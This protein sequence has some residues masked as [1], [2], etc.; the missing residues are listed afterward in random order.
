[1]PVHLPSERGRQWEAKVAGR[2][3]CTLF[4]PCQLASQKKCGKRRGSDMCSSPG[5]DTHE[6][7]LE[8][9][10][11]LLR[12]YFIGSGALC[13]GCVVRFLYGT[14]HIWAHDSSKIQYVSESFLWNHARHQLSLPVEQHRPSSYPESIFMTRPPG[15]PGSAPSPV[16]VAGMW[17]SLIAFSQNVILPI[18]EYTQGSLE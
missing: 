16:E 17:E 3:T 6:K 4:P 12:D 14:A 7:S 8:E 9:W 2:Q 10:G 1:M 5:F 13:A 18:G 11:K 15:L